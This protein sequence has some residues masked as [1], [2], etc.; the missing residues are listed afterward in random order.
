MAV[1]FDPG[2]FD[3]MYAGGQSPPAHWAAAA[4]LLSD[5]VDLTVPT[6]GF[7]IT[8]AGAIKVTT[9]GGETV[10]FPS[11]MFS[12]GVIHPSQFM[13]IWSTGTTATLWICW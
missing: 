11:G 7:V 10:T 6:R 4:S 12:T 1:E 3:T 13:R 8:V 5:T 9:L 2:R